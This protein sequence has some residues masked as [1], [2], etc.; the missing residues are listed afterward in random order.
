MGRPRCKALRARAVAQFRRGAHRLH[1]ALCVR[2]ADRTDQ[3]P[4]FQIRIWRGT[5][6]TT[7]RSFCATELSPSDPKQSWTT[8]N[9]RSPVIAGPSRRWRATSNWHALTRRKLPVPPSLSIPAS[10]TPA[11][12]RLARFLRLVGD[13]PADATLPTDAQVYGGPLVDAVKHF[14]GRHGLDAD[15]RLGPATVKELNVPLQDRVRQLQAHVGA[16]ALAAGRVFRAADHREYP[17]FPAS[18]PRRKQQSRD[19]H[20]CR[21]RESDAHANT[22]VHTRH[23]LRCP[24]PLLER[25]S[26]HSARRDRSRRSSA[27]AATSPART[28]RS[29]RMT[30]R[31]SPPERSPTKYWRN[32][33]RESSPCG[34][35]PAPPTL[36]DWSS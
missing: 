28:T 14:Q 11:W 1:H 23:E 30:A 12:P 8:W 25:S 27:T 2:P 31:W 32:C 20:A 24:P 13:L 15:G 18:R 4:A 10:H 3:S 7:W 35:S 21:R 26:E 22:C 33:E 6:S 19:G 29:P 34:R 17:R 5:R 16:L 9:L 36:W